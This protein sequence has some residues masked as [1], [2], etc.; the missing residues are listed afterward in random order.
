MDTSITRTLNGWGAHHAWLADLAR[1]AARDAVFVVVLVAAATF[2]AAGRWA[3]PE[4]RRG[5]VAAT[6]AMALALLAGVVLSGVVDR[7]RPFVTHPSI[8]L[9]MAHGR[10]AGFPSDHAT[11]AFAIAVALLL[12]HRGAGVVA[13]TFAVLVS[14]A[15][16]TVGEHYP[17]DVLGGAVLGA[18]TALGFFLAS[19]IRRPLDAFADWA[20]AT[21]DRLLQGRRPD[22]GAP[23]RSGRSVA[24]TGGAQTR[25]GARPSTTLR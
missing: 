9:L 20:G 12:R 22:D 10:D 21:Y 5:A 18:A 17:S 25:A 24:A 16:V 3:S 11:A 15:R 2:L 4:G 8:Q 19:W 7:A 14:V 6:A 13:L 23:A 1:L